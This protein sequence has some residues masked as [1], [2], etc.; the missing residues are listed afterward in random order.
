MQGSTLQPTKNNTRFSTLPVKNNA[1]YHFRIM[2]NII[3]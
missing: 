3:D 2:K 1:G